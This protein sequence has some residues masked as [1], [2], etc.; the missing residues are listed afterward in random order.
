MA[1]RS[2]RSHC[3]SAPSLLAHRVLVR[4]PSTAALAGNDD[5]ST[6][7]AVA[8]LPCES[9]TGFP[10]P[11]PVTVTP[12]DAVLV[13]LAA[14]P[15]TVIV[16]VPGVAVAAAVTVT[17]EFPPEVT[18]AGEKDT[19]TP[20]GAPLAESAIVSVPPEVVTVVVA[21]P[22][23]AKETDAG[24]T[25]RVNPVSLDDVN[26]HCAAVPE[27]LPVETVLPEAR[28]H[29]FPVWMSEMVRLGLIDHCCAGPPV[30]FCSTT[31][32]PDIAAHRLLITRKAPWNVKR[33]ASPPLH[34]AAFSA[35]PVDEL[36]PGSSRQVPVELFRYWPIV[37]FGCAPP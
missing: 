11:D 24:D 33:C 21:E 6:E 37:V 4:F 20:D 14:V 3:G 19:P 1:P 27:Q 36:L 9:S 7:D 8:G 35:V 23:G 34:A 30:H 12:S 10:P 25:P 17:V 5:D 26:V 18:D 31:E 22:P 2:T 32:L 13:P 16:D 15:L 29:F 28:M